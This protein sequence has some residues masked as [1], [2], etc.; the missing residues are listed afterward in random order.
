MTR[1]W[2][3]LA[4]LSTLVASIVVAAPHA[5]AASTGMIISEVYGG[6]GNSGAT[7]TND[8]VE[9]ANIGADQD[10]TGW[11]VQYIS[12]SP[13]ATSQWQVTQLSGTAA[14]GGLYLVGEGQG[15]GGTTPLPAPDAS[16]TIQMS[17]TSGTI[18]LVHGTTAL[19]CKTAADC[20]AVPAVVDLVGYG[21]AVVREG[22]DAPAASNTT[23]V[24]RFFLVDTDD[25]GAD[26][27][28]G[29]PTPKALPA[30]A[31]ELR[32]DQIQGTTY[33]SPY[34]GVKVQTDG[35]VTARRAFGS[36]RG[37]WLQDPTP[38]ADPA[39]SEGVFVFTGSTT[40]SVAVGDAVTVVGT[41]D[42]FYPD[43]SPATAVHP[44]LTEI[45]GAR[46]LT[47]STGNPL[48][49]AEPLLPDTV[50]AT[51]APT[52]GG[53][54]DNLTLHP[55]QDAMDF[56]ESRESMLVQVADARV[57]GPSTEFNELFVT[58]K[59]DERPTPR[60]GTL[61]GGYDQQNSGRLMV[62]SL[63]P[64]AEHPFP[65]ANV[66]DELAG[67][68]AG[69]VGYSEFG[70]YEVLATSLGDRVDNGL[71]R[72]VTRPQA[73]PELAIATYN[74][75]NLAPSDAQAKF[76][77]LAEGV[78]DHLRSPDIV[79]LEEIQDN[80][81][82]TDDGTVAADQT[83]G[84]FV[85]AIAAAGGP[86]YEWRSI[87]PVND[88]DGGQPGG[89]IRVGFLFNPARVQFV[90]RP[91]GDATTPVGVVTG[92]GHKVHLTISPGRIDP[93]STA[94]ESSRKPLVGEFVFNDKPVFVVANHFNSKGGDQ[95]LTSRFQPP[96]RSSEV[97]RQQQAHEVRAFVDTLRAQD[98]NADLVVLGDLNDYEFSP[99]LGILTDGGALTDLLTTLPVDER[100]S[101]VFQ[102]NSQSLDHILVAGRM[103]SV[104]YDVVHINAEF[105]DQASDHDPQIARIKPGK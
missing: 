20:A 12:A 37:F 61:Y 38:D 95:P 67:V 1:R 97:Q 43:A 58:T 101:Y 36:G 99:T 77:R 103:K 83:F 24:S 13:G 75:E 48:P 66:G 80:S 50:P 71:Q 69:P 54:I 2:A 98:P 31:T 84:K 4:G 47:R 29:P 68:T 33:V 27:V 16:G 34:D 23:S 15:A 5:S 22:S 57:V 9:L 45:T 90:D 74:V 63:I 64:F 46:W 60:G 8:F 100:Y 18:A 42:E 96:T 25:N 35:I 86:A 32:I 7:Y 21:S 51:F 91:G 41:V 85:D 17:A 78:V 30:P 93:A 49:T 62:E 53:N 52:A 87:D 10:L 11:S 102:G 39:T 6:G 65:Q 26:F 76:D 44:S 56:Y 105:A 55:D 59:P 88:Q 92:P 79:A 73:D 40:P 3:A 72:E 104:D 81:G 89:N 19:T 28:T 82:A 70:G 94:W 14:A